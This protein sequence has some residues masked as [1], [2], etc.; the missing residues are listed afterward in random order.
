LS[1]IDMVAWVFMA[2]YSLGSNVGTTKALEKFHWK[3]LGKLE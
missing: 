2:S 1:L 3:S